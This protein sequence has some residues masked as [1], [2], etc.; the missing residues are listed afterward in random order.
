MNEKRLSH[1]EALYGLLRDGQPHSMSECLRAG[2]YRYGGRLHELRKEG[3]DIETIRVGD[4]EF[5]YR[6]IRPVLRDR[7]AK[8]PALL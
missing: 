3:H 2:G 8:Q 1:K 6:L 7:D 4:D 5:S